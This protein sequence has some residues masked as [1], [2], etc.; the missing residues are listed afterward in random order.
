MNLDA[1]FNL[2][3]VKFAKLDIL[4]KDVDVKSAIDRVNIFINIESIYHMFHNSYMEDQLTVMSDDELR[5]THANIIS[6]TINLASHYR[7]FFTKN[8]IR[9]NIVF[10]MNDHNQYSKLNNV[11]HVKKYRSKYV[12]DYT[13]NSE[14][15]LTNSLVDSAAKALDNIVDY[16]DGVYFITSD[17][18]ESSLIPMVMVDGKILDGQLNIMVTRDQYDLQYVNKKFLIVYPMKDDGS[19]L[20]TEDN[21]YD[22]FRAKDELKEEYKLPSYLYSF[23]LS[24]I[25]DKRRSIGKVKGVGLNTIY[26]NLAKLFKALDISDEEYVSFEQLAVSIKEDPNAPSGN[27]EKVINNYL[28]IDIDRQM[29]MVSPAQKTSLE[30]QV[31]DRYDAMAL[32]SI[33]DKYFDT[34]PLNIMELDNYSKKRKSLF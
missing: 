2:H 27:R 30:S 29:A 20:I 23:M 10:Y 3:K 8:K 7:L 24:V 25:G 19:R 31:V 22:V 5:D 15:E 11:M 21:L 6:N 28:S 14:F 33:N 26:K 17:R 1:I 16:I 4:F 32:K 12:F 18:I 13:E 34:C 9:T